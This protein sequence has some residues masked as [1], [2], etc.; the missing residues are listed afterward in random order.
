MFDIQGF[1]VVDVYCDECDFLTT[2]DTDDVEGYADFS[3]LTKELKSDGWRITKE[4]G[5]WIHKCPDCYGG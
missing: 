1:G 5:D 2:I 4:N 3:Y